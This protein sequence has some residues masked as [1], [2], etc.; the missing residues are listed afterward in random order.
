MKKSNKTLQAATTA[1]P[2]Y[3]IKLDPES[4]WKLCVKNT[5]KPEILRTNHD[6]PNAGRLGTAKTIQRI[7]QRYYWPGLYRDVAKYVTKC[8]LC[9]KH[10]LLQEKKPGLM[11]INNAEQPWQVITSDLIGPLP[12]S[13]KGYNYIIVFHDKFTK[14]TEIKP[15]R[16]ATSATCIK[17]L[18]ESIVMKFGCPQILLTDN[19]KQF[20]SKIF[21]ETLKS[22]GIDHKLTAP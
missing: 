19:G 7:A 4:E 15:L 8:I 2:A 20:T 17:A 6:E 13:S 1:N 21:Q 22:Y 10:K 5:E 12:R 11:H 3:G 9:Q 18:K 16:T 14:W